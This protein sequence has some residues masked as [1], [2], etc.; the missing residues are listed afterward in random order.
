LQKGFRM[1]IYLVLVRTPHNSR[2]TDSM[3]VESAHA[4]QRCA[5]LKEEFVRRGFDIDSTNW[6]VW[7]SRAG[8]TD[9]KLEERADAE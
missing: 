8:I 6:R 3:W 4:D 5:D 2:Y 1:T 7:V 9:A